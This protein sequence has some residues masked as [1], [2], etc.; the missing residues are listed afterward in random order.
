ML[1][2][3]QRSLKWLLRIY[4]PFR[5]AGIRITHMSP[6]LREIDVEMKLHWWNANAVGTHYG[7]SLYS[8][9]DPFYML[10]LLANLGRDYV[11]W[12]KVASIRFRKPGKGRVRAEFR[13]TQAQ[14]DELRAQLEVNEKIEP[15]FQVQIR[16]ERGEVV[17]EVEKLLHIRRKPK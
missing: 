6:D 11:V 10:M 3:K 16:D 13:L 14:L 4:P 2:L 17:A 7:G 8:M 15:S 12:D 5:G 1:E 9:A